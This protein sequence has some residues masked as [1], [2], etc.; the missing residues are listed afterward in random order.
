MVIFS[1]PTGALL[2]AMLL[3]SN[4]VIL[5]WLYPKNASNIRK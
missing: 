2:L 3:L 5:A 4:M 1:I